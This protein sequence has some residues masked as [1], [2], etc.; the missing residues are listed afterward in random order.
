MVFTKVLSVGGEA[1]GGGKQRYYCYEL[2]GLI[3]RSYHG[4]IANQGRMK[5]LFA[6]RE[7][8]KNYGSRCIWFWEGPSLQCSTIA[9]G[10]GAG[11]MLGPQ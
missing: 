7:I 2:W 4:R 10:F 9:P 8:F 5:G 1:G 11:K 6:N 3:T